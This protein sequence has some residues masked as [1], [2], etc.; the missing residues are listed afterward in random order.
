MGNESVVDEMG[1]VREGKY[2]CL[3]VPAHEKILM[4]RVVQRKNKGFEKILYGPLPYSTGVVDG[5]SVFPSASDVWKIPAYV[6]TSGDRAEGLEN[7]RADLL[8]DIFY[9]PVDMVDMLF[10]VHLKITPYFLRHVIFYPE[11]Q[12]QSGFRDVAADYDKDFGFYNGDIR[13]VVLPNTH[14]A[15]RTYNDSNLNVYTNMIIEY[16]NYKVQ[17]VEDEAKAEEVLRK[18]NAKI[19]TLPYIYKHERVETALSN[20]KLLPLDLLENARW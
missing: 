1:F 10:D 7:L 17:N 18:G 9:I 3:I 20:Y 11:G 15:F 16:A 12:I 5:D 13:Y 8:G 14:V 19:E 6:S 2:L 4:F